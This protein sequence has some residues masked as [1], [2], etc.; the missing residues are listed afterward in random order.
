MI[1]TENQGVSISTAPGNPKNIK[2]EKYLS[3][4]SVGVEH[5]GFDFRTVTAI[6]KRIVAAG[7]KP[8]DIRTFDGASIAYQALNLGQPA[9]QPV[10]TIPLAYQNESSNAFSQALTGMNLTPQT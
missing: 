9:R 6:N 2:D 10:R 1:A 3:G 8:I 4:L 5:G 7:L